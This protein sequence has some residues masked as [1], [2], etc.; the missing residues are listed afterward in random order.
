MKVT[1]VILC[2]GSGTRLWPL[3]RRE[4][5]KQF[6]PLIDGRTLLS[7]TIERAAAWSQESAILCVGSASHRFM[8]KEALS[9]RPA[10]III[11]PS[12]R[13]TAAAIAIAALDVAQHDPNTVMVVTPADHHIAT[14]GAL[15]AIVNRAIAASEDGLVVIGIVPKSAS[16]NYGYILPR[17]LESSECLAVEEF[18][19]KP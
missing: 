14:P 19:E 17:E 16:S 11:E 9:A 12:P 7:L 4:H 5:P 6:V 1:P 8:I 18:C 2:G 3:S 13:N 10:S 15:H